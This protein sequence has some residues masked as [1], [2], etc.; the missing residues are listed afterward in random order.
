MGMGTW[1]EPASFGSLEHFR[2]IKS[3]LLLLQIHKAETSE[4]GS[5]HD[6]T[7]GRE[8]IHLIEGRGVLSLKMDIGYLAHSRIQ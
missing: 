6:E 1:G 3:D 5:I 2:K 4:A 7:A 8:G